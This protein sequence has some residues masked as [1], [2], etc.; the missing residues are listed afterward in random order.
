MPE[1][2]LHTKLFAPPL[3]PNLVLRP[4]LI[5]R[6]NQGLVLGCRLTLI[7]APAGFGK[8][9]VVGE[10]VGELRSD[11]AKDKRSGTKIAWLSLD[12]ND[13]DLIRFLDYLIAALH[14]AEGMVDNV[15]K[16]ALGMLQSPQPTPAEE[17]LTSLINDIAPIPGRIILVL[18]DYQFIGVSLV[19][20]ALAFLLEH[21]PP[22]MHLVIVTRDDPQLPLARLRARCQLTELRAADLRFSFSET[23]EF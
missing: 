9:T 16:G 19:N 22:Q 5:K 20:D 1:A 13:N 11:S 12:E 3:R 2:L 10:W 23:T 14:Q 21:L 7:S 8:T 4:R 17:I 18:D 6:L 15:G